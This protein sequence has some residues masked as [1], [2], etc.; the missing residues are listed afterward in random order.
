MFGW[1]E[2]TPVLGH[3]IKR[4]TAEAPRAR[5]R[6]V[7]EPDGLFAVQQNVTKGVR[8]LPDIWVPLKGGFPRAEHAKKWIERYERGPELVEEIH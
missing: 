1:F 8:K 4:R 6:I 3:G 2:R 5:L 7:R